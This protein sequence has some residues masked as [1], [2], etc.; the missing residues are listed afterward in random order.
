M[1]RATILSPVGQ[2]TTIPS[3]SLET[4]KMFSFAFILVQG[5]GKVCCLLIFLNGNFSM[6]RHNGVEAKLGRDQAK[7][8]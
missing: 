3:K 8:Q 7:A 1:G 4:F 5:G 6:K 2:T